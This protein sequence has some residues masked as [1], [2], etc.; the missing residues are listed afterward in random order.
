MQYISQYQQFMENQVN[1]NYAKVKTIPRDLN[2][3]IKT[4][5]TH[6]TLKIGGNFVL[7]VIADMIMQNSVRLHGIKEIVKSVLQ[8]YVSIVKSHLHRNEK[9]SSFA[10]QSVL[11]EKMETLLKRNLLSM[12]DHN[13]HMQELEV[14]IRFPVKQNPGNKQ[15]LLMV[16]RN[17]LESKGLKIEEENGKLIIY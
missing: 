3:Q 8:R 12:N 4:I 16:A 2:G 13:E 9:N 15:H 1:V 17:K 6:S 11:V 5:S 7:H 10:Q 14:V